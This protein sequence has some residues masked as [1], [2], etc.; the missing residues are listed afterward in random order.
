MITDRFYLHIIDYMIIMPMQASLPVCCE[1]QDDEVVIW[2]YKLGKRCNLIM[3][4]IV[5]YPNELSYLC[6]EYAL[7]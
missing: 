1:R 4:D 2:V 5:V 3:G 6:I 7:F